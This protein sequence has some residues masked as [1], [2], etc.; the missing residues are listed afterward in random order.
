MKDALK[1]VLTLRIEHGRDHP[2]YIEA[3]RKWGE[4]YH[5]DGQEFRRFITGQILVHSHRLYLELGALQLVLAHDI[6]TLP[7]VELPPLPDQRWHPFEESREAW[8]RRYHRYTDAV[9]IAF[10]A[11][12]LQPVP[13]LR[14]PD[15][16]WWLARYQ[17]CEWSENAIAKELKIDQG[18]VSRAI[19]RLA[20]AVGL[21][22]RRTEA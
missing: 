2:A 13:D 5:V 10:R 3:L 18:G 16:I 6:G 11:A 7:P 21:R 15:P 14:S 4:Q 20:W 1:R 22:F 12:G 9:E 19:N 8:L 17:F